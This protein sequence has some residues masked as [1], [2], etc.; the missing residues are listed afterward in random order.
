MTIA[1][2]GAQG[3][4]P[5]RWVGEDSAVASD[6]Q[7]TTGRRGVAP[8]ALL[9]PLLA[10]RTL[11]LGGALS[12][13]SSDEEVGASGTSAR[14]NCFGACREPMGRGRGR[15]PSSMGAGRQAERTAALLLPGT[16][17]E[18]FPLMGKIRMALDC[19]VVPALMNGRNEPGFVHIPGM[20]NAA[21]P[22]AVRG[23]APG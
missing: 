22:G 4:R 18:D 11:A 13:A 1:L 14:S 19:S 15:W 16:A 10:S 3:R 2:P 7:N 21:P 9:C 5:A 8:R 17:T 12:W 6:V 23:R 20:L